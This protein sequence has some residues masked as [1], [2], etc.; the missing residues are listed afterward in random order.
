MKVIRVFILSTLFLSVSLMTASGAALDTKPNVL[1]IAVDDL[2]DW[3]TL[4]DPSHPIKMPHLE[5]LAKRGVF[6]SNAYCASPACNPS[7]VAVMTGLRPTT[8]GV[9]GNKSKW[10]A[11]LPDVVTIPQ[12]FMK[13]GYYAAGAGKIFHHGGNGVYHDKASF[14]EFQM[15]S[16][17]ICPPKKLNGITNWVG[18]RD[19]GP[20]PPPYDWGEWPKDPAD[21]PDVKTVNYACNFLGKEHAKPFFLAVGIFRPHS[22]WYAPAEHFADYP[23]DKVVLPKRLPKDNEDIPSG[24]LKLLETGKPFL[25]KTMDAHNQWPNAVRAYQ[26]CA[27][28]ADSQIGRLLDGLDKSPY[29]ANTIVVLWSDNGFHLGEK[30]HWE[31]FALWEKTTRCPLIVVAPGTTKPGGRCEQPVNLLDIYPTLL[32]LCGLKERKELE[33]VSLLPQLRNVQAKRE[34]PVLTTWG[35]GNHAIRSSEWRLIRYA[36]GSKELYDVKADPNDW[37]N[38]LAKKNPEQFDA[39]L[40]KLEQWLPKTE[41][42]QVSDLMPKRNL[43][44]E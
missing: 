2:N 20:T 15:L 16:P 19:G 29:A 44:Q 40:K 4:Y 31:K 42:K 14:H 24:G 11:A 5:R 3:T 35:P 34:R 32:E 41:A 28:F 7:R 30:L 13:N 23:L 38:L 17:D 12:H 9:Y 37:H 25:F 39:V 43:Q 22:P 33:G 10:R 26:A 1:F 6:F 8:T 27:S 18:G 36:D 21:T